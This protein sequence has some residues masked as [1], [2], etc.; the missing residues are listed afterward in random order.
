MEKKRLTDFILIYPITF[1]LRQKKMKVSLCEDVSVIQ[2]DLLVKAPDCWAALRSR[3]LLPGT[4]LQK[5]INKLLN[6]QSVRYI[7]DELLLKCKV[8]V[9]RPTAA[10]RTSRPMTLS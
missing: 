4:D 9:S 2:H 1:P 8:R 3:R 7:L 10:G 5:D 6:L